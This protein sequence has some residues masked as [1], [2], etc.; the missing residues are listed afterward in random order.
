M[1]IH[2]SQRDHVN[3]DAFFLLTAF[4]EIAASQAI[5]QLADKSGTVQDALREHFNTINATSTDLMALYM[6]AALAEMG[7]IS[8]EEL[9]R[10]YITSYASVM[11]SSRFGAAGAH[12][13][14]GMIRFNIFEREGVF[15]RCPQTLT[16]IVNVE[17]MKHAIE[18]SLVELIILQG[19]GNYESAARI[20]AKDGSMPEYF[21]N[22]ID[23]INNAGIPVDV[24]FRQGSEQLNL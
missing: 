23:R 8:E 22:D 18:K 2:E 14:A 19:D 3:A 1:M 24:Y 6:I 13:I 16:Y 12:G 15:E 5:S 7:E 9:N 10:A 4:H 21:R 17:N 20:I 11:R